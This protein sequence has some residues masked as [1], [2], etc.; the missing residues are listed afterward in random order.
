MYCDITHQPLKNL[1]LIDLDQPCVGFRKFISSWFYR[2][3]GKSVLV[4][5]GP[6]S[7]VTILLD[8][9]TSLGVERLDY[10]LITHIHID[11][12]GGLGY[13]LKRYPEAVV[14]CHPQVI[15]H[16][17]DPSKL[18]KGSLAVL[19]ALAEM[20]GEIE[21]VPAA[22]LVPELFLKADGLEI[23]GIKTPG[24]ASHHVCYRLGDLLFVGEVAG[25]TYPL[26]AGLYLRIASPA[27]FDYEQ[28][29]ESVLKVA[30]ID[31]SHYCFAHYGYRRGGGGGREIFRSAVNQLDLWLEIVEKH[32]RR[33]SE[34]FE[35]A[36][37]NEILQKDRAMALF[38][39]LP[40]DIQER[41]RYFSHNS[42]KG[43]RNYLSR[44]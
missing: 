23:E 28:Y 30:A 39:N 7:S 27:R 40:P 41:E 4:D 33:G 26:E 18:W 42:I 17:V 44:C 24:H 13:L 12:V 11:H 38:D 8:A 16:L 3:D 2:K 37:F 20:Y 43:M 1:Y 14:V 32:R 5:P 10:I 36:V 22:N 25:V 21:P 19:G 35:D 34:P 29:R 6:S 31:V 15:R 9:L